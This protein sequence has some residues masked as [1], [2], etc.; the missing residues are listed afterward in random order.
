M[1][2]LVVVKMLLASI[3]LTGCTQV[4]DAQ[5]DYVEPEFI[6]IETKNDGS[7]T[8]LQEF[9]YVNPNQELNLFAVY[10][11]PDFGPLKNVLVDWSLS[12]GVGQISNKKDISTK[13][14]STQTGTSNLEVKYKDKVLKNITIKVVPTLSISTNTLT[15]DEGSTKT[16]TFSLSEPYQED[17]IVFLKSTDLTASQGIDYQDNIPSSVTINAGDTSADITITANNDS[18]YEHF[19]ESFNIEVTELENAIAS[20]KE[21]QIFINNLD[22]K[23]TLSINSVTVQEDVGEANLTV[24]LSYPSTETVSFDY[25]TSD[26]SALNAQDYSFISN[27]G[28]ILPGQTELVIDIPIIDNLLNETTEVFDVTLSNSINTSAVTTATGAITLLDNDGL[29]ELSWSS[30][31]LTVNEG[32]SASFTF[33]LNQTYAADVTF[34]LSTSNN[35]AISGSDYTAVSN[36]LITI[37]SGQTSVSAVINTLTDNTYEP[38]AETVD[39]SITNIVNAT[40]IQ[41]TGLLTI[42]NIDTKPTLSTADLTVDES[43]G[44]AS[45]QVNLS[46]PSAETVTVDYSSSNNTAVAP[47]D[48][49]A[50]S[51]T[52][53]FSPGQTSLNMP[54]TIIDDSLDEV[55][56]TLSLTLSNPVNVDTIT[57]SVSNITITDNDEAPTLNWS[58]TSII[59]S[60]GTPASVTFSLSKVDDEDTTFTL[61]SSDNTATAGEDYTAITAESLTIPAGQ[62]SVST[63]VNLIADGLYQGSSELI[64]LSIT[65]PSNA[66]PASTTGTVQINDT[67]NQPTIS[68]SDESLT[69]SDSNMTFTVTLSHE[70]IETITIDYATSNNTATSGTDYTN[71][72]GTLSFAPKEITKTISVPI[73]SDEFVEGDETFNVTLSNP[74]NISSINKATGVGTI[75]DNDTYPSLSWSQTSLSVNEGDQASITFTLSKT[76][77]ED[78]SFDVSTNNG[79]AQAGSDYTAVSSQTFTIPSGQ[80]SVTV[81]IATLTDSN[82][83]NGTED[84]SVLL[85][86]PTNVTSSVLNGTVNI[87]DLDNQ[88]NI[89]IADVTLNESGGSAEFVLTLS[90]RS[91]Q[92]VTVDYQTN[93]GTA[94]AGADYTS[95]SGSISI[96]AGQLTNT[97]TITVNNDELV[98]SAETF[99]V[100]LSNAVNASSITDN[101]AIATISNDDTYP[102]LTWSSTNVTAAEGNTASISFNLSK[103]YVEDVSFNI[104]TSDN[105]ATAGN[106]YTAKSNETVTVTAGQTS[107]TINL[108]VLTD[109]LYEGVTESFS[110]NLTSL[111]KAT[112]STTTG[113]VN[114]TD[115]DNR[116]TIS[117]SDASADESASQILLNVTLSH[118]SVETISFDYATSNNTAT[119]GSDYTARTGNLSFSPLETSRNIAISLNED[120]LVEGNETFN[121]NLSNPNNALSI[122]DSNGIAAITDNDTYPELNWSS[123]NLTVTEGDSAVITFSL[124]K[125]YPEDVT[126]NVSTNNN[127][128]IAPSDYSAKTNEL[129]TITAGQNTTNLSVST[130]D[131]NIY[132]NGTESLTLSISSLINVTSSTASATININDNDTQPTLSIGNTSINENLGI[133][134]LTATLSRPSEQNIT[135]NYT[136]ENNTAIAGS[137][138]TTKSGILT[139][140]AGQLSN[141]ISINITNDDV[142]E[143][144][145]SFNVVL[146]NPVNLTSI[147]DNTGVVTILNDD[148]Y[149]T[150]TWSST[151]LTVFE[152]NSANIT[153]NLSKTYPEDITFNI[154]T[155]NGTAIAGEDY[156]G[157]SNELITI[158]AGQT[159]SSTSINTLND[160]TYEGATQGFSVNLSSLNNA[161]TSTNTASV[162]ITDLDSP[163]TLSIANAVSVSEESG[164]TSFTLN[165]SHKTVQTVGVNYSTTNGSALAGSDYTVASGSINFAPGEVTKTINVTLLNDDIP[166]SNESF[167]MTLSG[168]TN[169]SSITDNTGTATIT[170]SDSYPSLTWSTTNLSVSE[171]NS[172]NITFS[173]SKTYSNDVTFQ[174]STSNNTAQSGS[175][176]TAKS[177]QVVTIPSGS[178]SQS[179]SFDALNDNYYEH[180]NESYNITITNLNNVTSSTTTGAVTITNTDLQP[181]ISIVSSASTE[182]G[183]GSLSV[184]VSINRPSTQS[185][186]VDYTS[187]NGSAISGSD[188][189]SSSGTLSFLPGQTIKDITYTILDD[190]VVELDESFSVTLSNPINT[191]SVSNSLANLT[192]INDDFMFGNNGIIQFGNETLGSSAFGAEIITAMTIDNNN[193]VYLVGT[194]SSSIVETNNFYKDVLIIKL[195]IYGNLDTS[196]GTNGY[197]QFGNESFGTLTNKDDYAYAVDLDAAGNI[198]IG[199]QTNGSLG[200]TNSNYTDIFIAKVKPDGSIDRSYGNNGVS[201]LGAVT[202]GS[203]ANQSESTKALVVDDS[204]TAH[205][206]GVTRGTLGE[207]SGG[208]YDIFVAKFDSNGDLDSSFG[209]NGV[210]QLGASTPGISTVSIEFAEDM[211]IDSNGKIYITGRLL[212][213]FSELSAGGYDAY[214]L[215]LNTNGSLDTSFAGN[216]VLHLG[217]TTLGINGSEDESSNAIALDSQGRILIGG[218]SE[219]NLRDTSAGDRDIFFARITTSGSLDSTFGN[220]GILHLGNTILGTAGDYG[221][222]IKDISLDSNDNIYGAGSTLGSLSESNGGGNDIFII[223]VT[224]NGNL[225]TDFSGDGIE[226]IGS[227]TAPSFSTGTSAANTEVLYS[228]AVDK[229]NDYIFTSG[230]TNGGS[231]GETSAGG[232]DGIILRLDKNGL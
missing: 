197:V 191:S 77:V 39:L 123:T 18:Y 10:R 217:A 91:E 40:N 125:T 64:N 212:G 106:D 219:S 116:P 17:V 108:S 86:N 128:A 88:P 120:G 126:F 129:V 208:S 74:T 90:H 179:V 177:N 168:A 113:I 214:V 92:S 24:S 14:L 150:L 166:E 131:D 194:T 148:S 192:I 15:L 159:S 193:N 9:L 100:S 55:N 174:V 12:S 23:P 134:T 8:P 70:S 69:E 167:N 210:K 107:A 82:Y 103:S 115:S 32:D 2:T 229:V 72:S 79:T 215:R 71:T 49:T 78:V 25:I 54:V 172:S 220:S 157:K 122:T 170:D 158:T 227:T 119:A 111:S 53:S 83:D 189:T 117:I 34:N 223:K 66:T 73:I 93:D 22:P 211:V 178:L 204:G 60:E 145:E 19:L 196:F 121:V 130:V 226:H 185:I 1:S 56:Q 176:Y 175:D 190:G 26:V 94:T 218:Y 224:P 187:S 180:I 50:T 152:G 68:I 164:S 124:S 63:S 162:N 41:N 104:S 46:G 99:T 127:T 228:I 97:L 201:Q 81:N 38:N 85:T 35:T 222:E 95:S 4:F 205:L 188:Y 21:T 139:I 132:D 165:L 169:V 13:F 181:T 182:E 31:T 221:D 199:G 225:S 183:D 5:Y 110:V 58:S 102:A 138:Y 230:Y 7:G 184:A 118:R 231:L 147:T 135:V 154:S 96:L 114:I 20:D 153:F 65:T 171:G 112:T 52:L 45:V 137:D 84:F 173:L 202:I 75:V 61:S 42:N 89:S 76:Y 98:E 146:S 209:T 151:N 206:L 16:L 140:A 207:T 109:N 57:T 144:T 149:P 198:Y 186:S 143:P 28:S 155:T 6:Q 3:I 59:E 29:P 213:D 51:G 156:T 133:A 80:S 43:V 203:G 136:T 142:L 200:E 232:G 163:P 101:T 67:D 33:N 141:T 62:L 216:G 195:D 30:N 27:T 160:N 47:E 44:T 105:T 37:P 36:Q 87:V 161:T 48:Y 11:D